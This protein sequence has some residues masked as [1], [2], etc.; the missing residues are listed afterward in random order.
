MNKNVLTLLCLFM[1][2]YSFS[3]TVQGEL[4]LFTNSIVSTDIDFIKSTDPNS[5]TGLTYIGLERREM[6]GY[7]EDDSELFHD[8]YVFSASYSNGEQI[9]IT[10]HNSFGNVANAQDYAEKVATRLGLLPLH[11][12][13]ALSH[14]VLHTG[15]GLAT[16]D[17]KSKFFFLY[18]DN[19]DE[20][21]ST[22]DL[23]ETIF[24][25]CTHVAFEADF[26]LDPAWQAAQKEDFIN[27]ITEYALKNPIQEDFLSL[28]MI[29]T[30]TKELE[31]K[32][33]GLIDLDL[34]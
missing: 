2:F 14:V 10:C 31:T 21:I 11:Y 5:Y 20:R 8:A 6:P 9:E 15:D 22:N 32:A 12:R 28:G 3:Q 7:L 29:F 27:F 13:N 23:E 18:A 17:E 4:P 19:I 24:H 1:T 16:A 34:V 25:E 33:T 26:S 30:I